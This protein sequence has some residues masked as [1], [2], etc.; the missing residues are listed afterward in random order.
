MERW[1]VKAA[2]CGLA[3][4]CGTAALL[5]LAAGRWPWGGAFAAG[6]VVGAASGLSLAAFSANPGLARERRAAARAAG[7]FDR[8]LT[9]MMTAALPLALAV[10][11]LD[12]RFGWAPALPGWLAWPALGLGLAADALTWRSLRANPYFSSQVRVQDDRGQVVIDAGPYARVRHPG[13][14]GALAFTVSLP[15]A[16]GSMWGLAAALLLVPVMAVRIDT[17][18]RTLRRGLAGYAEY[19][20]RVRWRVLPWVW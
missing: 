5:C 15:L 20:A 12:A 8:A 7:R 18:E 6:A 16:L 19:Q 2:G 14:A 13:Y 17:E 3:A 11:A 4:G 1:T 10:S 9:L